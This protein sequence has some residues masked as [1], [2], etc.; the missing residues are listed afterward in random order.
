MSLKLLE[1]IENILELF[2]YARLKHREKKAF[3]IS[4]LARV[5][6]SPKSHKRKNGAEIGRK[7]HEVL[8]SLDPYTILQEDA[9]SF[10]FPL[11]SEIKVSK[12]KYIIYG[13]PD[14][15]LFESGVPKEIYEFKSYSTLDRYSVIQTQIYAYLCSKCFETHVKAFLILGWN[16]RSC[17]KKI[18]VEWNKR[19]VE[20]NVKK[21]IMKIV[22]GD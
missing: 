13:V 6:A 10:P 7:A 3:H 15:I 4:Q 21:A 12:E 18:K 14:L 20:E 16:G 1:K 19:E 5:I 22:S 11:A 17:K 9:V 8:W 2:Q